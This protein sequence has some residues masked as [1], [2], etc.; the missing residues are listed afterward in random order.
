MSRQQNPY[1]S[2]DRSHRSRNSHDPGTSSVV[3]GTYISGAYDPS[4]GYGGQQLAVIGDQG[5]VPPPPPRF[6]NGQVWAGD[7]VSELGGRTFESRAR[8]IAGSQMLVPKAKYSWASES[9]GAQSTVMSRRSL[10]TAS[11]PEPEPTR[12]AGSATE[13]RCGHLLPG[14]SPSL[15]PTSVL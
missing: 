14:Y 1:Y 15:S 12:S 4:M 7:D 8:S 9:V 2:D 10:A 5:S 6:N 3:S 13:G 11:M